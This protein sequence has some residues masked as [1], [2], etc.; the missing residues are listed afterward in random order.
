MER[1][2]CKPEACSAT[3]RVDDKGACAKCAEIAA[4]IRDR[5]MQGLLTRYERQGRPERIAR[6]LGRICAAC[7]QEIR[8]ESHWVAGDAR[9]HEVCHEIWMKAA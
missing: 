6:E 7:D 8:D 5:I 9:F 3:E 1:E 2:K 4:K